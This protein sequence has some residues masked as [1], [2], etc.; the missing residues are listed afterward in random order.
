LRAAHGHSFDGP[1]YGES[2]RIRSGGSALV[3]GFLPGQ[4]AGSFDRAG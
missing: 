1:I 2:C 3:A 4:P